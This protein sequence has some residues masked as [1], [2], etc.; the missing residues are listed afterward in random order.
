MMQRARSRA[1]A[2]VIAALVLS[3]GCGGGEDK[4]ATTGGYDHDPPC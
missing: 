1:L 3:A 2:L 4:T